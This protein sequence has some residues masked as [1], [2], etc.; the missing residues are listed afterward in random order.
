MHGFVWAESP[1][2]FRPRDDADGLPAGR[3]RRP[4]PDVAPR[5]GRGHPQR[6]G[7]G[8]TAITRASR[9][10]ACAPPSACSRS[11]AS[12]RSICSAPIRPA[13]APRPISSSASTATSRTR[14]ANDLIYQLEASRTYNPLPDL[15]R[16]RVPMTWV[17]SAP[18]T[19][20]TRPITASPKP[21]RAR[22]PTARYVL[23]PASAETRGHGTH[24]WA[25]FWKDE[26]IDLL[27]R[28]E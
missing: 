1:S 14:D 21:P 11:P 8:R 7:L 12:R 22:M 25:R 4:Q 3:D 20:S 24:T 9:S 15:E 26:L 28:T 5:R 6:P 23:I 19:S 27:R 18:T 2:R 17:N 16:I 13:R 10:R